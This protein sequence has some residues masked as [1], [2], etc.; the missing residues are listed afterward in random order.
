MR[1]VFGAPR[2]EMI[3]TCK[4][5]VGLLQIRTLKCERIRKDNNTFINAPHPRPAGAAAAGNSSRQYA[6]DLQTDV[7]HIGT[8]VTNTGVRAG[9]GGRSSVGF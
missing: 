5:L 6:T 4:L 8:S 9:P 7:A 2:Q 3:D 1:H